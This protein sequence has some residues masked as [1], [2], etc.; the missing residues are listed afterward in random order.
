[1]SRAPANAAAPAAWLAALEARY[2]AGGRVAD[3]TRAVRALSIAYVEARAPGR[4]RP[5]AG[6]ARALETTGKRAAFALFYGPLHFVTLRH[7]VRALGAADPALVRI[8]DLGCG[9]G[10]AGAAW[11]LESGRRPRVLGVERHPWAAREAAWTYRTLGVEG[12][13][14][15]ADVARYRL[16][17][18]ASG[19]VAAY[20]LNELD[21]SGRRRVFERLC[22]AAARGARV[23]VVEPVARAL[24]PEWDQWA[25]AVTAA[26]GRADEWRFP[27]E[28]PPI[29]A[30]LDGAAGLDHRILTAR[31]LW[32]GP[33]GPASQA[34]APAG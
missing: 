7:I 19:I 17:R 27:A 22:A 8:V 1:M 24:L 28:L 15:R 6:P 25:R 16:P 12:R 33:R 32:L 5:P 13:V 14:V 4:P 2:L 9:T 34:F 3:L 23:L 26:G 31:S 30:R 18:E 20:V 29:V 21:A 10:V 11:S